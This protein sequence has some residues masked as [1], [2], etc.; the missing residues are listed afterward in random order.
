MY[1]CPGKLEGS[2]PLE[3]E[4]WMVVSHQVGSGNQ[5]HI[6]PLQNQQLLL[7]LLLP[8]RLQSPYGGRAVSS[9][10]MVAELSPVAL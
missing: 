9:C 5:T 4:L 7:T 6:G 3:L 1:V 2:D 8:S 10:S